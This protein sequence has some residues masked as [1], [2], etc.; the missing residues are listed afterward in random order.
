VTVERV[1][2]HGARIQ[3]A[4]KRKGLSEERLAA[5]M[6][7]GR[8]GIG[9][10]GP[11]IHQWENGHRKTA[12]LRV[13]EALAEELEVPVGF[14]RYH[15]RGQGMEHYVPLEVPIPGKKPIR[16]R[17]NLWGWREGAVPD[18]DEAQFASRWCSLYWWRAAVLPI[19]P[20]QDGQEGESLLFFD[21]MVKA[22]QI[23][24]APLDQGATLNSGALKQFMALAHPALLDA[25]A[26]RRGQE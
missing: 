14:L 19:A 1:P 22:L 9:T 10:K 17:M 2:V 12:P 24:L 8:R 15:P 4:R 16:F 18:R 11:S 13:L 26:A 5:R 21:H 20:D 25:A 3:W 7:Q 23:L 6:R